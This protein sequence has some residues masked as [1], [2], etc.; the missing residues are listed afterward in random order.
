MRTVDREIGRELSGKR[1]GRRS[2]PATASLVRIGQMICVCEC[3]GIGGWERVC[4]VEGR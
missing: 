1:E 3:I 2:S 4:R